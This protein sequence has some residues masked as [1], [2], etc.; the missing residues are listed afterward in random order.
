TVTGVQTCALPISP[1]VVAQ[2]LAHP[3]TSAPEWWRDRPQASYFGVP[4]LVGETFVGVLDYIAPDGIPDPEEQETL[5]LLAAQA[6]IAV[7]N[8]ALY[9]AERAEAQR[10]STL[11]AVAQRIT[12]ALELAELL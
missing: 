1:V 3:R 10:A 7:R 11:A 4:I 6:G 12:R 5:R 2:P 9:Q 8:A